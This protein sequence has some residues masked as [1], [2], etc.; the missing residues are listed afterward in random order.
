MT[1]ENEKV[2]LTDSDGTVRTIHR[3]NDEIINRAKTTCD[4]EAA[5]RIATADYVIIQSKN[6]KIKPLKILLT[7]FL[8]LTL[9][10]ILLEIMMMKICKGN[11]T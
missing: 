10:A 4:P 1:L 11:Q 6:A 3:V 8:L 2:S 5:K 7:L 9:S